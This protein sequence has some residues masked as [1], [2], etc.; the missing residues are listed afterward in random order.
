MSW[1]N[2]LSDTP[3]L[4]SRITTSQKSGLPKSRPWSSYSGLALYFRRELRTKVSTL[5][6]S[7]DAAQDTPLPVRLNR[8][9]ALNSRPTAR[10]IL[11]H[12]SRE[13]TSPPSHHLDRA[14][15]QTWPRHGPWPTGMEASPGQRTRL[16]WKTRRMRTYFYSIQILSVHTPPVLR[17]RTLPVLSRLDQLPRSR[18]ANEHRMA[19]DTRASSS[20]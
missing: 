6:T 19:Q 14:E 15:P 5:T 10:Y 2:H 3:G 13:T 9:L 11:L 12:G 20:P 17:S 16:Q 18:Q 4:A 1:F 7:P 8:A